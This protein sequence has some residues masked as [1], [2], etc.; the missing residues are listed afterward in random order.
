MDK[1]QQ[2]CIPRNFLNAFLL[3]TYILS[4]CLSVCS[5]VNLLLFPAGLVEDDNP[6]IADNGKGAYTF[7]FSRPLRTMDRLQQVYL[8]INFLLS[9]YPK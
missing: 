9:V 8:P 1:I 5:F 4:L 7:E 6:F 2:L 3:E